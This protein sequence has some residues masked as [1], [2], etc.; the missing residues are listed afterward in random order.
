MINPKNRFLIAE[1]NILLREQ[2]DLPDGLQWSTKEFREGWSFLRAV[3]LLQLEKQIVSH[4]W[5]FIRIATGS[6]R[7]GVGDT[8]QESIANALRLALRRVGPRFNAAVVKN[9]ELTQYPWFFMARV[10]VN[11]Y[12]IQQEAVLSLPDE[13]LQSSVAPRQRRLPPYSDVLFPHF[14]SAMP[15]LKELLILSRPAQAMQQ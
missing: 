4:D 2:A 6:L 15:Q 3:T 8:A 9:I 7:C 1:Q 10:S 13:E 5:N 11:P 14:A 12:R